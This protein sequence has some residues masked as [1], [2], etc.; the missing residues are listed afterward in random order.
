[1]SFNNHD[2]KGFRSQLLKVFCHQV[3]EIK[4]TPDLISLVRSEAD[5]I[6]YCRK[7]TNSDRRSRRMFASF[8]EANGFI[9]NEIQIR[10]CLVATVLGVYKQADYY[11]ILGVAPN[12]DDATIKQA[13]RK[14]AKVLHPD[15]CDGIHGRSDEFIELHAAYTH[16]RDPKLRE[17]YDA[18]PEVKGPWDVDSQTA[19]PSKYRPA[20][21]RVMGWFCILLG[22]MVIFAYVFNWHNKIS[23]NVRSQE[24]IKLQMKIEVPENVNH[25]TTVAEN[26]DNSRR[27]SHVNQFPDSNEEKY[28]AQK[29][30]AGQIESVNRWEPAVKKSASAVEIKQE[31]AEILTKADRHPVA[32]I[33][34]GDTSSQRP[35]KRTNNTPSKAIEVSGDTS[36]VASEKVQEL[37]SDAGEAVDRAIS[38]TDEKSQGE[39]VEDTGNKIDMPVYIVQKERVLSFL[40]EY[41]KTYEGRDL[42]K[43]RALFTNDAMEQGQPFEKLVPKYQKS[44]KNIKSMEYKIEVVSLSMKMGGDKILMDGDFTAKFRLA[45]NRKGS[46]HGSIRMEILDEPEGLLV[47]RL[48]YKIG[49]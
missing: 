41:T 7:I 35:E 43:F 30:E 11:G 42:K 5:Y 29:K 9:P 10:V 49:D 22:S 31:N 36:S 44:F 23:I 17:V 21:V 25:N 16:L 8:C 48:D 19:P 46:S 15:K 14:K 6:N 28:T 38:T 18:I 40:N 13:Y 47:T 45:N 34:V 4:K 27:S 39:R 1:M 2:F 12:A 26:I 24:A 3:L 33:V 37:E 20:V 32:N